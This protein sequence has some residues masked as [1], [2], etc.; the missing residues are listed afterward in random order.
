[1]I[2]GDSRLPGSDRPTAAVID[3]NAL[4]HN[5]REVARMAGGRKVLAVVK[6]QAY[7]HGA[8]PVSRICSEPG[9][10]Y[11]R[12]RPRRRGQGTSRSRHSGAPILVMGALVPG[13]AEEI[14]VSRPDSGGLFAAVAQA[15]SA[16]ASEAG[17]TL[18]CM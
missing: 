7:G 14:A 18:P 15:L 16:A 11:A 5:F 10:R 17:P 13:Q 4:T 8:V 9:R 6:A 3:L 1:M 12:R 2:D